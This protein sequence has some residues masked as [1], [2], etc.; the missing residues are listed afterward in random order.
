MNAGLL[1]LYGFPKVYKPGMPVRP[2]DSY[3][4][5]P[6]YILAKILNRWFRSVVDFLSP[7]SVKNLVTLVDRVKYIYPPLDSS[8]LSSDVV[9]LFP[10]IPASLNLQAMGEL[11]MSVGCDHEIITSDLIR[12]CW[13]PNFCQYQY[14]FYVFFQISR[15]PDRFPHRRSVY[16]FV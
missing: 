15:H 7:Y 1:M 14:K 16:E 8:L 13:S 2:I 11:F 9:G 10:R 6:T 4:S 12:I 3:V 5:A